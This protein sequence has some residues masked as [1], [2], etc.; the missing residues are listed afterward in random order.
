M[1][2]RPCDPR[3]D[4]REAISAA[5]CRERRRCARTPASLRDAA[6][7]AR[8]ARAHQRAGA[9]RT[10]KEQ[11]E[12]FRRYGVAWR[13]RCAHR[14]V[15]GVADPAEES[16]VEAFGTDHSGRH[17]T[18]TTTTECVEWSATS[19]QHHF[20][21]RVMVP[22]SPMFRA[23]HRGALLGQ[24][25]QRATGAVAS[26]SLL[27]PGL[28]RSGAMSGHADGGGT[29]CGTYSGRRSGGGALVGAAAGRQRVGVRSSRRRTAGPRSGCQERGGD[30]QN[31]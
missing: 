17:R 8:G 15:G 2:Q 29:V 30:R 13:G 1:Q 6:R 28:Q 5:R 31:R 16:R 12:R 20:P 9:A 10:V 14:A 19:I 25:G 7:A 18:T 23:V 22:G 24:C 26:G 27:R 11:W 4:R 3:G 21:S